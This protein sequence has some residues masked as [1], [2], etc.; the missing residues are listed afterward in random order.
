MAASMRAAIE[1]LRRYAQHPHHPIL[2]EGERGTGKTTLA[3]WAHTQSPRRHARCRVVELAQ[4]ADGLVESALFGHVAGA[5]TGATSRRQGLLA[6][7]GGGTIVLDDIGTAP[8]AFQAKL[9]G[10]FER[11]R[12]TPVGSDEEVPFDAR[13]IATSNVPLAELVRDGL[14][15]AD[16][17]DRIGA[18]RVAIPPLRERPADIPSIVEQVVAHEAGVLGVARPT[19]AP[20]LMAF[21]QR[22]PWPGNVRTLEMTVA[23]LVALNADALELRLDMIDRSAFADVLALD[24]HRGE[25]VRA[26]YEATGENVSRTAHVFDIA[27]ETLRVALRN[28]S[29]PRRAPHHRQPGWQVAPSDTSDL[30]PERGAAA[31]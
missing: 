10:W 30:P 26:M 21:L 17:A 19:V 15:R 12:M 11:R 23:R 9:L 22:Q 27:R 20:A 29:V 25:D 7:T 1:R 16:V 8:P 28:A 2:I 6:A 31:G 18:F 24:H 5:Y 14:F 13:F 3:E 4:H